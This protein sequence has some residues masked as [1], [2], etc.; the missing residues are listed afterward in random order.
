MAN[1]YPQN[2]LYPEGDSNIIAEYYGPRWDFSPTSPTLTTT[3]V[4]P[5]IALM[6]TALCITRP[7]YIA[8]YASS[9]SDISRLSYLRAM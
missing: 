3:P 2:A 7:L 4:L 8:I 6:M 1:D 5:G 9:V